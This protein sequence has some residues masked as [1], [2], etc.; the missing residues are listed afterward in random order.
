M[1][2]AVARERVLMARGFWLILFGIALVR[3]RADFANVQWRCTY[4]LVRLFAK[5]DWLSP[6]S[7]SI[8]LVPTKCYRLFTG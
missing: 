8:V 7:C 3:R 1:K 2:G 5:F 6:Q 4:S